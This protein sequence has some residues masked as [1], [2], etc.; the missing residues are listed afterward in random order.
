[1]N[2]YTLRHHAAAAFLVV[3]AG[4]IVHR[5]CSFK[6]IRHLLSYCLPDLLKTA[7]FITGQSLFDAQYE[8]RERGTGD[9]R[10]KKGILQT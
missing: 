10:L 7:Y 4:F 3:V 9:W 5:F 2:L 1:M 6:L 8:V